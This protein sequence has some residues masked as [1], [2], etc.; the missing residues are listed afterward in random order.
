M[1]DEMSFVDAVLGFATLGGFVW[2]IGWAIVTIDKHRAETLAQR[3]N[4]DALVRRLTK[5]A[6]D[7]A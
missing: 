6:E 1:G 7:G 3:K 2:V 4:Q 5:E